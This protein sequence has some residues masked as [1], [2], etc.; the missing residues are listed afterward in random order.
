MSCN[1]R[2]G[3][4]CGTKRASKHQKPDSTKEE[5]GISAKLTVGGDQIRWATCQRVGSDL[6]HLEED[7]A[8]LLSHLQQ[9]MECTAIRIYA[10]CFEIVLF[11]LCCFPGTTI[12]D[13]IQWEGKKGRRHAYDVSIST[14]RS[15]S[16][17]AVEVLKFGPFRTV[18]H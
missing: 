15:V 12:Q 7:V 5:V 6:P 8:H 1:S 17:F 13:R 9:G 14:V 11:E 2:A 4:C 10:F 18:N 16:G 3:C